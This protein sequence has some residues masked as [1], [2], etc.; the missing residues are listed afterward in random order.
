MCVLYTCESECCVY[1]FV[2][3]LYVA[4]LTIVNYLST[5]AC[6]GES[7][8]SG[9]TLAALKR[10]T[11]VSDTQLDTE[12]IEHNLYNLAA[13]FDNVDTYILKLGLLPGQ[14]TDIKDLAF[15]QS[16]QIA[17]AEALKLWRAPNPLVAT[18]RALLIILLDLK[19]GDVAVRVCQYIAH[20]VPQL[21]TLNT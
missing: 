1:R 3:F 7:V 8:V 2:T 20:R 19:R 5:H 11:G 16:T 15:R 13:C 12:V 18:F 14:Q 6:T 17:M 4:N 10:R 9:L 21:R